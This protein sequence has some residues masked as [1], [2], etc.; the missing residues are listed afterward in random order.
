MHLIEQIQNVKNVEDEKRKKLP[1]SQFKR[2]HFHLLGKKRSNI[3]S[4]KVKIRC[5]DKSGNKL[6]QREVVK[7]ARFLAFYSSIQH[8]VKSARIQSFSGPSFPVF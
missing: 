1:L 7:V 5:Y 8:Y 4:K 6:P 3:F 2:I